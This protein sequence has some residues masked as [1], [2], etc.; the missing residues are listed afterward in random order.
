MKGRKNITIE[1]NAHS[2]ECGWLYVTYDCSVTRHKERRDNYPDRWVPSYTHGLVSALLSH[3]D[4][5][6]EWDFGSG[7]DMPVIMKRAFKI[8]GGDL[9]D[10]V[11]D[12]MREVVN[13]PNFEGDHD[14]DPEETED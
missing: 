8:L 11:E 3:D 12:R 10:M 1:L 6:Y 13:N 4:E 5:E 7:E 9:D 2:E 14:S